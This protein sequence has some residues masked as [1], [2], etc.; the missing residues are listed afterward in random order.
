M[1]FIEALWEMY[2]VLSIVFMRKYLSGRVAAPPFQTIISF[3]QRRIKLALQT[4]PLKVEVVDVIF[5]EDCRR[6]EQDGPIGVDR[7]ITQLAGLEG[8]TRLSLDL[9]RGDGV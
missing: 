3:Q 7:V 6:A 1:R 4:E 8:V 5:V 9:A 2:P